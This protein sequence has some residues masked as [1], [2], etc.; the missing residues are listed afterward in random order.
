MLARRKLKANE[1]DVMSKKVHGLFFEKDW[2]MKVKSY[3]D[4]P[5][6]LYIIYPYIY[7]KINLP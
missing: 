1:S 4:L 5:I 2:L 3:V 6:R 7:L